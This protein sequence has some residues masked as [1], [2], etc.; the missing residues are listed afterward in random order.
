MK[1][2]I[3]AL[4]SLAIAAT[5][6][7]GALAFSTDAATN[8]DVESTIVAF[9]SEGKDKVT[10]AKA[11][12]K[13]PVAMYIPQS[14]GFNSLSIKM[15]INGKETL[16]KGTVTDNAG[17]TYENYKYAFGNYGIKI[18]DSQFERPCCLESGALANGGDSRYAGYAKTGGMSFFTADAYNI[19]YQAAHAIQ[20]TEKL[21][22][23]GEKNID[24]Y[25]AWE[26]A[27]SPEEYDNYK[28]VWTWTEDEAWA[29]KTPLVTFN[30]EL[31]AGIADGTYVLDVY[32]DEFYLC[33]PSA[34]FDE[35]TNEELPDTGDKD[36]PHKT[37]GKSGVDG[38]NAAG[39]HVAKKLVSKPLTIVV[40]EGGAAQTTE[41]PVTTA[42]PITT[43]EEVKTTAEE[44]K[45]TAPSTP[46]NPEK[47]ETQGKI[48]GKTIVYDLVP[49]N[50]TVNYTDV[51]KAGN[52][53]ITAE[54]GEELVID[55]IVQNDQAVAGL[56]MTWDFSQ[57]DYKS[58]KLGKAY[59]ALPQ[60]NDNTGKKGEVV[61]TFGQDEEETAKEKAVIYT[62][63]VNAPEKE[64]KYSIQQ[65]EGAFTKTI[66]RLDEKY[67]V[68]AHGLDI[69]VQ[70]AGETQAP[71]T[72]TEA[73]V[74]TTQAPVT[75]PEAPVT[76]TEAPVT[77]TE[78][79]VTTTQA[80]VTT[81]T[82]A[83]TTTK[84]ETGDVLYGDV[85]CNGKVQINDVVL[86]NRY[87]AKTA[88]I[89]AQGQ[90]NAD[91]V[92]DGNITVDD[93]S[94]IKEFLARIITALPKQ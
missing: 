69:N 17:K 79:I 83:G 10:G 6:M 70:K 23:G 33:T 92:K 19:Q 28:P 55:W 73:P 71:V 36:T 90:K 93:S 20:N 94:A 30:L 8:G 50:K 45:T 78:A 91:C 1:K 87:L 25:D 89:T 34:L 21:Y 76:T 84:Q 26:A 32:T 3:S 49:R 22:G 11:G 40:G 66:S 54:P 60:F 12:D 56:Q 72:T 86:L 29:Y 42:A 64:G 52:N 35:K 51:N 15:A 58:A 77:T 75:T 44:V 82:D 41:A 88:D 80:P 39:E 24:S 61:Y 63:T 46:Q 67:D 53:S 47:A 38:A 65:M 57:V 4:S 5:A 18:T 27:G 13:I 62:F 81:V 2:F 48:E 68:I 43:A 9:R 85:N 59:M 7:G 37:T 74:T 16:G 31:P 14:S